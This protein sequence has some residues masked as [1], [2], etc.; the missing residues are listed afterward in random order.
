MAARQE[1]IN[2]KELRKQVFKRWGRRCWM[3]KGKA[4]YLTLDHYIPVA[5]GGKTTVENLRPACRPCNQWKRDMHPREAKRLCKQ[6]R[7]SACNQEYHQRA[8]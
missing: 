1:V 3:C 2:W 5:M 7:G 8:S 6:G 4:K